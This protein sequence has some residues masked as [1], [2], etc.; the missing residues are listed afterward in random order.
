MKRNVTVL[1]IAAVIGTFLVFS[2]QQYSRAAALLSDSTS[3]PASPEANAYPENNEGYLAYFT[4]NLYDSLQLDAI[5]L[6]LQAFEQA[7][8]GWEK[9]RHKGILN[10]EHILT[11]ADFSQPSTQKRLYVIDIKRMQ[12]L[13]NTYVAHGRNSGKEQAVSYSNRPSSNQSSP[14]FYLTEHTYYGSN[15]YSLKLE[16]LEKGIN[17]NADKR[18]IVMHGADYVSESLIRSQGYLGRSQ[19]CPAIPVKLTRPII[20]TIKEGSCLFIYSPATYY[21]ERSN[22]IRKNS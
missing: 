8:T 1:I 7:L 2:G 16:G 4:R 17:D 19:G 15:G 3:L 12:I 10:N 22:L 6:S 5:G 18:A 11:I 13:F 14:G 9:L 20:N 21:A